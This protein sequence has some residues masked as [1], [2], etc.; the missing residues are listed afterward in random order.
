[1]QYVV[2]T[3]YG[4][5][6]SQTEQIA[7]RPVRDP[8]GASASVGGRRLRSASG[9]RLRSASGRRLLRP[10]R[11]TA[12]AASRCGRWGRER[13]KAVIRRAEG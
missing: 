7:Q 4:A 10:F 5:V 11:T 9:R 3:V 6:S 8:D 12:A 2:S 1:M 13:F